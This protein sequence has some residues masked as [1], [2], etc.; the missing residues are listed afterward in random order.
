MTASRKNDGH[1]RSDG[2]AAIVSE[3]L[4]HGFSLA[5]VE[6]LPAHDTVQARELLRQEVKLARFGLLIVDERLLEGIEERERDSL[7]Q[8][9]VPLIIA[10]PASMRW[11]DAEAPPDDGYVAALI[12]RAVGYQLNIQL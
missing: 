3:D 9:P 10:I 12:R 6:I 2:V 7:F 11:S 1:E 5:G 8:R 4:G